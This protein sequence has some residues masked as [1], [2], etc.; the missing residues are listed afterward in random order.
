MEVYP[1]H[2]MCQI[3]INEAN[4]NEDCCRLC[5]RQVWVTVEVDRLVVQFAT[6][7]SRQVELVTV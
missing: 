3:F 4:D 5:Y 1:L 6:A 2:H 7:G